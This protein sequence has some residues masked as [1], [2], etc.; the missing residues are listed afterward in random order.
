MTFRTNRDRDLLQLIGF[1]SVKVY[2]LYGHIEVAMGPGDEDIIVHAVHAYLMSHD[3]RPL[4]LVY[5]DGTSF[6]SYS[7][8]LLDSRS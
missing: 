6:D 2:G 3:R 4:A 1:D 8:E 5:E 7:R